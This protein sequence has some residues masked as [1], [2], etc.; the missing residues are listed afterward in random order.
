MSQKTDTAE[1]MD[2]ELCIVLM[3]DAFQRAN[4]T[5]N[6]YTRTTTIQNEMTL[7]V[8]FHRYG[9]LEFRGPGTSTAAMEM[10]L[11]PLPVRVAL[12]NCAKRDKVRR[13]V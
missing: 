2:I 7:E 8:E 5:L 12:T 6:E 3:D 11:V 4:Q 13:L 10:D 1:Q 9:G